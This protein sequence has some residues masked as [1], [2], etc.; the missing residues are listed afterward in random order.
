MAI[1]RTTGQ[2][3]YSFF[4]LED[5]EETHIFE[6]KFKADGSCS[7]N[8]VSICKKVDRSNDEVVEIIS[9]LDEGQARTRA[10]RIGRKTCGTC[11]SHLYTT[12][13]E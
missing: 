12:Y 7:R 8:F 3:A 2:L 13:E 1:Q 11:V 10:A 5:S 6:G 9:C 4:E